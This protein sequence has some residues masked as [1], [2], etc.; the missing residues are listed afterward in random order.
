MRRLPLL[1]AL[2]ALALAAPARADLKPPMELPG[3][4]GAA[5]TADWIVGARP[6]AAADAVAARHGAR[7][8][9]TGSYVVPR[10]RARELATALGRLLVYAEP[11]RRAHAMQTP[12]PDPLDARAGWRAAIVDP[13]LVPPP[14]TGASPLLA[15]VDAT[16]DVSHPEFQ[17]GHLQTIGGF[18]LS[19][20]HGTET[21]AV[22]GAPKNDRGILGV[23]P[24]LREVNVS[25]PDQI[26]CAN[27]VTGIQR[28]I[29]QGAS[30]IN[31]SYGST[32]ACFAEYVQLQVA[33]AKGITLV[34]ASGN[35]LG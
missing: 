14:V 8:I 12:P 33:T 34:A 7:R 32:E 11:N 9:G 26:A 35:E 10:G 31:M 21:A 28:A 22:A 2:L 20:A 29:E 15:L 3:D 19:N 5:S 17:G 6:G 25:L 27:S 16:A 4:A 13:S 18:P 30:V 1:T 24:G 23:W